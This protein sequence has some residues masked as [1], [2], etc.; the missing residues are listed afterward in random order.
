[1]ADHLEQ[2]LH[3]IDE[4]P[5]DE[6]EAVFQYVAK[7][8]QAHYWLVAGEQINRIREIMQP[9]HEQTD[10]MAEEDINAIIDEAIAEVRH[11]RRSAADH[12]R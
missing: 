12:R 4:L 11:G 9:V 3:V 10:S 5:P 6:L 8:R 1:M 2:I 7:R